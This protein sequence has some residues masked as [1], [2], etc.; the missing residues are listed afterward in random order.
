MWVASIKGPPLQEF[1]TDRP[2][3]NVVMLENECSLGEVKIIGKKQILSSIT[4]YN[5]QIHTRKVKFQ[6]KLLKL[7][8]HT[9]LVS[10]HN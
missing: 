8:L 9:G 3:S 4:G 7:T 1:C 2:V 10:G 6:G 5:Q